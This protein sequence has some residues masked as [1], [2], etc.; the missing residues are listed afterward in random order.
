LSALLVLEEDMCLAGELLM[1]A[2]AWALVSHGECA[3]VRSAAADT[4]PILIKSLALLAIVAV[5]FMLKSLMLLAEGWSG[6]ACGVVEIFPCAVARPDANACSA[7]T[8]SLSLPCLSHCPRLL[9]N[10]TSV[11]PANSLSYSPS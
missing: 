3:L 10:L 9:V 7:Y 6:C 8:D 2:L 5:V 4:R 1:K 11:C